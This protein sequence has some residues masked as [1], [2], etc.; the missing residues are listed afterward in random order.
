M[1]T[2]D[3]AQQLRNLSEMRERG[4][5]SDEEFHHAKQVALSGTRLQADDVRASGPV[6]LAPSARPDRADVGSQGGKTSLLRSALIV[7]A[8]V[9]V[10]AGVTSIVLLAG[11]PEPNGDDVDAT[12]TEAPSEVT[13]LEEA[14]VAVDESS[15]VV[16]AV[17]AVE[18]AGIDWTKQSWF[19][20]CAD[21]GIEVEV[22]L[23]ADDMPWDQPGTIAHNPDPDSE[24]P[25]MVY[26]VDVDRVL[27]GDVTDDGLD[28][29]VF[30]T[31]CFLGNDSLYLVEVWG[32]DDDGQ[33]LHLP[34]V[35]EYSKWHGV[36][37]DVEVV[38][39]ALRIQT[40]E[41]SPGEDLPHI[42]GYAIEVVTDW[43]FDRGRWV[44]DEVSRTED[45]PVEAPREETP[46]SAIGECEDPSESSAATALCLVAAINAQ[47]YS[48]AADV[49]LGD[50]VEQLRSTREEW[51]PLQ[52]EFEGCGWDSCQFYEPSLDPQ[53]HGVTIEMG[54]EI[55]GDGLVVTWVESYG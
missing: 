16:E 13:E 46:S 49:A 17:D 8:A 1:G 11:D 27:F 2:E 41:P 39:A 12:A 21:E 29:A 36:I 45:A 34:A 51:G 4:E 18:L 31:E 52:W 9:I 19:T 32:H 53:F 22:R 26:L 5:L 42:N 24:I 6:W 33:P 20:S 35:L 10:V 3:I 50:V 40:R 54:V 15:D 7:A 37:D 23:S 38:G 55:A 47:D 14:P 48:M 25:G 43:T 30:Q 28:N 44:G